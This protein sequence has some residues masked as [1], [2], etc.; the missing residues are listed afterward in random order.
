MTTHPTEIQMVE[1]VVSSETSSSD[2]GSV[3]KEYGADFNAPIYP[4][5]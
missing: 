4:P 2:N 1:D 3:T 5:R